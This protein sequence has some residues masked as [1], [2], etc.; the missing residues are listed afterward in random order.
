M[1]TLLLKEHA[2]KD[3]SYSNI[4]LMEAA[5]LESPGKF[6]IKNIPVPM[7][8]P[9]E[10]VFEVEGCGVC[11]SSLPIF[12]GRECYNYPVTAGNP[13]HECWGRVVLTGSEVKT[14]K[15]GDRITALSYNGFAIYDKV[16]IRKAIRLPLELKSL[17]F[18]G[19]PLGSAMNIF[20]RSDIKSGQTVAVIGVGFLGAL[21]IQ[22]A[23]SAGAKVI[24][25]SNRAYSLEIAKKCG[26]DEIIQLNDKQQIIEKVK[27]I[28]EGKFCDRVIEASG[29]ELTLNLS[30]ELTKEKGKLVIA[31]FHEPGM[32]RVNVHLWNNKGIDIINAHEK[33]T[34]MHIK[35]MREA[36]DAVMAGKI[37]TK[38]LYTHVF[39]LAEI[40]KAFEMLINRPEGFMKALIKIN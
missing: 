30:A 29:K 40:N 33:D 7:P 38:D 31:G 22:L 28:T 19:E 5:I 12:Q 36:V 23:K 11:A 20:K 27:E 15:K 2:I 21:I 1:N 25:L 35:G 16:D 24:A 14:F 39:S 37:I 34:H 8:G 10:V 3:I 17:D 26:A 9:Q 4:G 6:S 13:G 32:R 18:P